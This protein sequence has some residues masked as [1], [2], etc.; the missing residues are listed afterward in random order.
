MGG[1]EEVGVEVEGC[2]HGNDMAQQ[3]RVEIEHITMPVPHEI[4]MKAAA[5]ST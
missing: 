3:V 4:P 5:S 1:G 2:I